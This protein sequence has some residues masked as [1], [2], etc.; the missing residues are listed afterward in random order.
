VVFAAFSQLP[1]LNRRDIT[2]PQRFHHRTSLWRRPVLLLQAIRANG[3]GLRVF[4]HQGVGLQPPEGLN[5]CS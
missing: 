4:P 3:E 2:F 5:H 1:L